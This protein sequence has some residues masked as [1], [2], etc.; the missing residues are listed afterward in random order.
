MGDAGDS[1]WCSGEGVALTSERRQFKAQPAAPL[2]L[3]IPNSDILRALHGHS[4]SH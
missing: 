1:L 4:F 3:G 2:S